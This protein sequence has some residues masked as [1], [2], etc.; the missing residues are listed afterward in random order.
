MTEDLSVVSG[1]A[2]WLAAGAVMMFLGSLL[3]VPWLVAKLPAD[4][5]IRE[6]QAPL[7]TLKHRPGL[8]L[9]LLVVKNSFGAILFLLGV[10]MLVLPGQGLLTMLMGFLLMDIPGKI[11]MERA[12][13]AKP[14]VRKLLNHLRA[15]KGI[16]PLQCEE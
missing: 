9:L 5:M 1:Y 13:L 10:L 14:G 8:R 15:R 2:G 11:R 7:S 4:Y 6:E 3:L 12:M 16:E